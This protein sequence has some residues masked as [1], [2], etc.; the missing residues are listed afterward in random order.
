[1]SHKSSAEQEKQCSS[2]YSLAAYFRL[3]LASTS[4]LDKVCPHSSLSNLLI[5][6]GCIRLIPY[7]FKSASFASPAFGKPP[8][9]QQRAMVIH[10]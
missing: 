6:L 9:V 7:V 3:S 4:W 10:L 5:S 8:S 1:M 2:L